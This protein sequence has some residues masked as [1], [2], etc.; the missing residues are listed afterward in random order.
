MQTDTANDVL[1]KDASKI[2]AISSK[3]PHAEAFHT[4]VSIIFPVE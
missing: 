3:N 2:I 4:R 1:V